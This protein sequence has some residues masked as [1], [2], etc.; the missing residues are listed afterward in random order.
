MEKMKGRPIMSI[1]NVLEEIL[2]VPAYLKN[3]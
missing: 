3:F 2:G 1:I